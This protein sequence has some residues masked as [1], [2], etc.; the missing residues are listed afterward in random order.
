MNEFTKAEL[1]GRNKFAQLLQQWQVSKYKFT[2]HP[3]DRIDC[4]FR[5]KH[6]W[7]AEIKVR[8]QEWDSLYMEV[9]KY[10]AMQ[11]MKLDQGMYVNFIGDKCYIFFLK[12]IEKFIRDCYKDKKQPTKWVWAN[13]TTAIDSGKEWKEMIDLPISLALCLTLKEGQWEL[14]TN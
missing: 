9:S 14:L 12:E 6:H 13:K 2:E 10:K 7:I 4:V 8:N 1:E 3:M 5:K 11:Q